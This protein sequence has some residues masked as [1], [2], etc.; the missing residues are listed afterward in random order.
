MDAETRELVRRLF[1]EATAMLEDV[2][3][4]AATGQSRRLSARSYAVQAERLQAAALEVASLAE[5]AGVITR[6]SGL[7][8]AH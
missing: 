7:K 6:R 8:R 2:H 4:V 1:V 3:E 5:A